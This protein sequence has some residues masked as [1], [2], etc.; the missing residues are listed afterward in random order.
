MTVYESDSSNPYASS[1]EDDTSDE[2]KQKEIDRRKDEE[3]KNKVKAESKLPSGASSKGTNTPSGRPKHSNPLKRPTSLKRAGSPN[4]SAS[5]ASGNESSRKKHKKKHS[6]QAT[7]TT[8]P[9][10]G[11]RPMSPAPTSQA[12]LNSS[13][14]KSSIIKLNLNP[15][16]LSEIQSVPPNPSP[17]IG[18][19]TSDGEATG[20]EMS[21]SGKRSK[22]K[23]RLGGSPTGSRAGSPGI[24]RAGSGGSRAGSP[25]SQAQAASPSERAQSPGAGP[26]QPHEIVAAIPKEGI[27][28]SDLMRVFTARVGSLP[29][30]TDKKEFITLVKENSVYGPDKRL[31]QK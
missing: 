18:G 6:S 22:I 26:I 25:S 12:A 14:R 17:V 28:I 23:L 20:G 19:A 10:P 29:G 5:E 1:S 11:S 31:R 24:G 21:D 2:E 9:I 30:Q 7:G 27:S 15:S 8:T 3:A 4:L 13:P 16:K